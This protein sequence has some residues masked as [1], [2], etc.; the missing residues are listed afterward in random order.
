MN[1]SR[2]RSYIAV[3]EDA[4][5]LTYEYVVRAASRDAAE[6]QVRETEGRWGATPV[7]IRPKIDRWTGTLRRRWIVA[8]LT[9][10]VVAIIIVMGVGVP[11]TN[12]LL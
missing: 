3:V 8:G 4:G 12:S 1:G 5:G 2:S 7:D 6:Q 9:I 10:A 11:L